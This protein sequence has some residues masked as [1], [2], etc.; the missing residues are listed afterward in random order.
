[1]K[2]SRIHYLTKDLTKN[3]SKP[4]TKVFMLLKGLSVRANRVL[5]W[6]KR[7]VNNAKSR[8]IAVNLPKLARVSAPIS[9]AVKMTD[10]SKLAIVWGLLLLILINITGISIISS[11]NLDF[12]QKA[13]SDLRNTQLQEAFLSNLDKINSQYLL[14][15]RHA[16][17]LATLGELFWRRQTQDTKQGKQVRQALTDTLRTKLGNFP[18]AISIGIWYDSVLDATKNPLPGALAFRDQTNPAKITVLTQAKLQ[19]YRQ[20]SWFSKTIPTTRTVQ[21][22]PRQSYWTPTYYNPLSEAA[23]LTLIKPIYNSSQ[24]AIGIVS[25]DWNAEQIIAMISQV[26]VTPNTFAYLIDSNN[27]K[28][29]GFNQTEN[30]QQASKVMDAIQQQ[31]FIDDLPKGNKAILSS[32]TSVADAMTKRQL[33]V[34]EQEYTLTYAATSAGML[35]GIGVPRDEIDA[36]LS[37]M[38]SRN[39]QILIFT[40][41]VMLLLSALILF[42]VLAL[43]R[44]LQAS[45]LDKLTKLPN[46]ARLLLDIGRTPH[47]SLILINLDDFKEINGLFGHGCGDVVLKT[48]A[49]WLAKSL[50]LQSYTG[51]CRLYRLTADE[52]ALLGDPMS[53]DEMLGLLATIQQFVHVQRLVWQRQEMR[54]RLTLGAAIQTQEPCEPETQNLL[55]AQAEYALQQARKQKTSF[56]IYENQLQVEQTYAQN[57]LWAGRLREA[58][59]ADRIL[60]YFQPIYDNVTERITKYE[61]LVRMQQEDGQIAY[62][63]QF[64]DIAGKIRLDRQITRTMVDKA[65]TKFAG[66]PY[67]FSI[68]LSYL[69]LLDDELSSYLLDKLDSSAMGSQVIFEILESDGI[70]NYQRVRQFIDQAKARGCRIAIDDFGTGY[71]NFEHLLRLNVDIIK[72]DGSLIRHLDTDPVAFKVTEGIVRFAQSLNLATVAEFVHSLAVQEKVTLLGIDFSQ[73]AIIAMPQAKL[74]TQP[75]WE[76]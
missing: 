46:R 18:D 50:Q 43:M 9:K 76:T 63:G 16:D 58:L 57:L 49:D 8:A 4:L 59:Q 45:Y 38:R 34:D 72:I 65:F 10:T 52:F 47:S 3:L 15:E 20:Q 66:Q 39:Y 48:M 31:R 35:F 7:A 21:E 37:P 28:L 68:N 75:E 24:Q 27:R 29:S 44:K 6:L 70:D 12:S 61:C 13:L 54:F 60:P 64:L 69:D 42:R 5:T 36:V 55:I 17:E 73:G 51:S 19:Q 1:M 53:V 40:G 62:P 2:L 26:N 33:S 41:M 71:S 67:D 22:M 14:L 30:P 74:V 11:L 23:V 32:L 56:M 25:I